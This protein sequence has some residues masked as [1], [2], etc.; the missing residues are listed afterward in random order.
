M[1]WQY[2]IEAMHQGKSKVY[3]FVWKGRKIAPIP[4]KDSIQSRGKKEEKKSTTTHIPTQ[5]EFEK[6]FKGSLFVLAI[7][8]KEHSVMLNTKT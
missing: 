8:A 3:I 5:K 6:E 7:F 2:D 1:S 4:T